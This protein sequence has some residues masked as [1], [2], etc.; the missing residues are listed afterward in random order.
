VPS[1]Y[2]EPFGLVAL[3]ANAAGIPVVASDTGG[4]PDII[5][6][7]ENGLLVRPAD[8][9]ALRDAIQ[10]LVDDPGLRK[11]MGAAGRLRSALFTAD[12]VVPQ[13]ENAYEAALRKKADPSEGFQ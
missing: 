3:E 2:R 7:G 10:T 12:A 9:L 1:I 6:H 13:F 11:R 4:L 8:P 5:V